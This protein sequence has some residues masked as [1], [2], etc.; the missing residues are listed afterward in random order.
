MQL[1]YLRLPSVSRT[2]ARLAS[3]CALGHRRRPATRSRSSRRRNRPSPSRS[4]RR[5][6]PINGTAEDP[7]DRHRAGGHAGSQRHDRHVHRVGRR[8]SNRATRGPK[9][10]S[11]ARRS[12][13]QRQF[14]NGTCRR[15]L[16]RGPSRRKS[17]FWSAAPP[18]QTVSVRLEPATRSADRRHGAGDRRRVATSAATA[19]PARRSSSRPT[20]A[21]LGIEQR[22]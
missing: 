4:V 17:K 2:A 12:A 20:T 11:R 3:G 15:V 1:L 10:A 9:A 6:W 13:R 21:S 16:G 8:R 19:C 22:R 5:R 14:G 18:A 7:R